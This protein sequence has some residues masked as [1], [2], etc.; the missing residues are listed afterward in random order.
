MMG[1]ALAPR[2]HEGKYRA[3]LSVAPAGFLL[4]EHSGD[5]AHPEF[6]DGRSFTHD[7]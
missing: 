3:A 4:G 7:S 2:V 1:M 5:S 6:F